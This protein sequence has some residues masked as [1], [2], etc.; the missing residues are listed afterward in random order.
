MRRRPASAPSKELGREGRGGVQ[1]GEVGGKQKGERRQGRVGDEEGV[2][3]GSE[4]VGAKG[5]GEGREGCKGMA[6]ELGSGQKVEGGGARQLASDTSGCGTAAVAQ[7]P[8]LNWKRRL[9]SRRHGDPRTQ[10]REAGIDLLLLFFVPPA[11]TRKLVSF[12]APGQGELPTRSLPSC[13][14]RVS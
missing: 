5:G 2:G 9:G 13:L 8:S 10:R 7:R 1:K 12:E 11:D 3:G 6:E 14:I 4:E